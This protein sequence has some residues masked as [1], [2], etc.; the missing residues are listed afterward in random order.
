VHNPFTPSEIAGT[1]QPFYGPE[2]P[3]LFYGRSSELRELEASLPVGSVLIQGPVGIGKSSLLAR[4]M[5]LMTGFDSAHT[6][7]QITI[8]V[9]KETTNADQAARLILDG[10]FA[11][12][13]ERDRNQFKPA[14]PTPSG[15]VSLD[16]GGDMARNAQEG[17]HLAVLK[18][19][20]EKDYKRRST[21]KTEFLL[22]GIDE[23]D[24]GAAAVARLI[25]SIT[26]QLQQVGV[27]DV[28]FVVAGVSP[29]HQELLA[30]D[31]GVERAFNRVLTLR[32]MSTEDADELMWD[33]LS[34]VIRHEEKNG[35]NL[36]V[37]QP[38]VDRMVE[39]SGGHPHILQLLGSHLIQH[40]Q[41]NPDGVL[42]L[43]DLV[44]ALRRIC[45]QDRGPVYASTLH[46]LE[47]AGKLQSLQKLV[48][49]RPDGL[50]IASTKYPT[51]IPRQPALDSIGEADLQWLVE[52]DILVPLSD[53]EY[54]LLDELL[55][56]RIILDAA[57]PEMRATLEQRLL[58][59]GRLVSLEEMDQMAS[60]QEREKVVHTREPNQYRAE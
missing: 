16:I 17:R 1:P 55:R 46:R 36:V 52:R 12:I 8:V 21:Q 40:E 45:Y 18:E 57:R 30:E 37:H 3:Q 58:E 6:G 33:K 53:T 50:G 20:L 32:P 54:G 41:G 11:K 39:L 34:Q 10:M 26:T 44:G 51:V 31:S 48:G 35:N 7:E 25:R 24:K 59:E 2:T 9:D 42:G 47:N 56:V 14:T 4:V 23:A 15:D 38:V 43:D 28:R 13:N 49:S 5:E 19:L 29:L 22:I 27:R 60:A